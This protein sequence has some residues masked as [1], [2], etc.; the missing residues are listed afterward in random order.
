MPRASSSRSDVIRDHGRG[1]DEKEAES[2]WFFRKLAGSIPGRV[3]MSGYEGIRR[4]SD[5][6][7]LSPWGDDSIILPNIRGRDIAAAGLVAVTGGV[8][9]LAAP[10]LLPLG[11]IAAPL[12]APLGAVAAVGGAA[13]GGGIIGGTLIVEIGLAAGFAVGTAAANDLIFKGPFDKMIPIYSSRLQTTAVKVLVATI[14]YKHTMTDAEL[15]YFRSTLQHKEDSAL[16]AAH[17]LKDDV[18][19]KKGWFSPYLFASARRPSIPRDIQPDVIFCHAP[20]TQ[21]DYKL[22][23][24]LLDESALEI[25]L[26]DVPVI[27]LSDARSPEAEI[28]LGDARSPSPEIQLGDV[29]SPSSK[30]HLDD[31]H[32]PY[33]PAP[34]HAVEEESGLFSRWF[35]APAPTPAPTPPTH[36]QAIPDPRRMVLLLVGIK[37]HRGDSWPTSQRPDESVMRYVLFDGCPAVVFPVRSGAPLLA[38]HTQ[39]LAQLWGVRLPQE[40]G[41]AMNEDEEERF[42][43]VVGAIAEF[44]G[45]CVDWER[46]RALQNAGL[47]DEQKEDAVKD[48]V[49]VLVGAAIRT[50][51][52]EKAREE[53]DEHRAGLAMWRIR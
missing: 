10:V 17:R 28:D 8:A 38:W 18:A 31:V 27:N 39:T 15:G 46:V 1:G 21:G 44:I 50:R 42:E 48:A 43:G 30:I 16:W 24:T 13:L 49:R 53:V 52:S 37:P 51:E 2:S 33:P 34:P 35:S 47:N 3:V 32:P 22:G 23:E 36:V 7:C 41:H 5:V 9:V 6:E 45:T 26:G 25:Q 14:Q 19:M 12:L 20:F 29:R 11:A 4:G 40:K